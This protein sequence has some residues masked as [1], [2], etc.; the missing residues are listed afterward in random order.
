ML[1]IG[2]GLLQLGFSP[3]V[4][5][6]I[7]AVLPFMGLG[8]AMAVSSFF[9]FSFVSTLLMPVIGSVAGLF[10][11]ITVMRRLLAALQANRRAAGIIRMLRRNSGAH[12]LMRRKLSLG[13]LVIAALPIPLT[14][15]WACATIAVL[16]DIPLQEAFAAISA[17]IAVCALVMLLI[18]LVVP[19]MFGIFI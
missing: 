17:G 4:A 14:G 11:A 13:L 19:G 9:G 8:R 1:S 5:A 2:F 6:F 10:F 15:V 3:G 7:L 12:R 18:A 16:L